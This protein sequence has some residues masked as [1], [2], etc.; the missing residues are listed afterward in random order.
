MTA[1][2]PIAIVTDSGSSLRPETPLV[3]ESQG[4]I[5]IIPLQVI[6]TRDKFTAQYN[7]FDFQPEVFYRMM[8]ESSTLP[9]TSGA[10]TGP[11]L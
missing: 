5:T 6:F 10:I 11:A 3:K 4:L 2:R 7:D 1:E 8:E 9:T